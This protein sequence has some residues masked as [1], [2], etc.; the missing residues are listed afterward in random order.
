[1]NKEYFIELAD[2][3]IWANN[4]VCTCFDKISDEQWQQHVVSS[5]KSIY[6]TVLHIAAS[7]KV[8]VER[9]KN[10]PK[11]ELLVN[12]FN[13]SKND[14]IKIWKDESL[15]FKRFI[16][17]FNEDKLDEKLAFKNTKGI[18]HNQPYWQL[19]AHVVNHTTYH[20]GQ[21]VTMLR[22][23]GYTDLSSMDMTTYFRTK[24][25]L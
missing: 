18:Q 22:Q 25:N 9:L 13:G 5:F 1:M 20:R 14:L 6:E 10:F 24:H 2:Y 8:W 7:E 23:V 15:N 4:I 3:H 19:F 21:L 17:D 12:T 16:E 11:H